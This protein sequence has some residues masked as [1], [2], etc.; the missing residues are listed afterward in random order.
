VPELATKSAAYCD[1]ARVERFPDRSH[2]VHVEANERVT[3]LLVE[4][5]PG[6][7]PAGD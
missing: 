3:E 5:L 1:D 4:H 2:W 6:E 7:S